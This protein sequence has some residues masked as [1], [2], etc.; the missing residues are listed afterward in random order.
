MLAGSL[1]VYTLC[2]APGCRL[3]GEKRRNLSLS[4]ARP[5]LDGWPSLSSS[6]LADCPFSLFSTPAWPYVARRR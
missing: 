3:K 6:P 2:W 5:R 1:L 4:S